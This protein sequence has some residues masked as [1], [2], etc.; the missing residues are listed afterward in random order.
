MW[1]YRRAADGQSGNYGIEA[2]FRL[3]VLLNFALADQPKIIHKH[4]TVRINET[5][6]HPVRPTLELEIVFRSR[7]ARA[8]SN[9][10]R[11]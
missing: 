6:N 9:T 7:K 4:I 2:D 10:F 1:L 11:L 5:L 3:P 8:A